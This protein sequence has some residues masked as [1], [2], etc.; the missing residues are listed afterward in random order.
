MRRSQRG[1]LAHEEHVLEVGGFPE[2]VLQLQRLPLA[3]LA[4]I[5]LPNGLDWWFG[6]VVWIGGLDW[7]FGLVVWIGGLEVFRVASHLILEGASH[8]RRRM[9]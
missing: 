5:L 4:D 2:D 3:L 7:W 6:L 9:G 8:R 1:T